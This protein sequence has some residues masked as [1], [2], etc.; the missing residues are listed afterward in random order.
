MSNRKL[1]VTRAG[2]LRFVLCLASAF[3]LW[4]F[5]MYTES[6]EY[7]RQYDGIRV[8]VRNADVRY[9]YDLVYPKSISASFRGTNVAL[10]GCSSDDITAVIYLDGG[11]FTGTKAFV[12]EYEFKNDVKLKAL[13]EKRIEVECRPADLESV[14]VNN[15][16][17]ALS[18]LEGTGIDKENIDISSLN[19]LAW[20]RAEDVGFLADA[21]ALKATATFSSDSITKMLETAE[22]EAIT[23]SVSV[24]FEADSG[25]L[26]KPTEGNGEVCVTVTYTAP[27]LAEQESTS[28][29]ESDSAD[30]AA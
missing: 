6:P 13:E 5:V 18:G 27:T 22:G 8:E 2:V 24:T 19:V 9:D 29:V 10:A 17:V 4:L 28:G 25:I 23:F 16:P 1:T 11:A 7:D 14:P 20:A 30:N 15:V 3:L 26:Y 12:V 21:S